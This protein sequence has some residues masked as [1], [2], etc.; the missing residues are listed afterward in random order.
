MYPEDVPIALRL[1]PRDAQ[2]VDNAPHTYQVIP[3]GREEV[4]GIWAPSNRV[5]GPIDSA[6][7]L[8]QA[9]LQGPCQKSKKSLAEKNMEIK[10]GEKIWVTVDGKN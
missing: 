6:A 2:P 1:R 10:N 9:L 5:Q 4:D 3:D 8:Y 7:R